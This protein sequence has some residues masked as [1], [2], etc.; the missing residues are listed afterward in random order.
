MDTRTPGFEFRGDS[1]GSLVT[2]YRFPPLDVARRLRAE[3]EL[4]ILARL[5]RLQD[6]TGLDLVGVEVFI[7][8]GVRQPGDDPQRYPQAVRIDLAV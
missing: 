2:P 8:A 1:A 3:A 4:E 5:Q 7:M 6:E